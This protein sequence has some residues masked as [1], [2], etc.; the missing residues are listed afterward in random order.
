MDAKSSAAEGDPIL[1]TLSQ[2][3][4]RNHGRLLVGVSWSHHRLIAAASDRPDERYFYLSMAVRERWSVRELER[5][6]ESNLFVRYVSVK[7]DPEKCLPAEA[8]QGDL[9]PFKDHYVFDFLGLTE[10]YAEREVRKAMLAN[11]RELFL[12]LG[13]DFALVGE[14][15]PI[16]LDGD[17]FRIDL[18]LFHRRLQCLVVLE[19]KNGDFKPEYVGKCQFYLAALDEQIRLPHEKPSIGLVLCRG[20]KG[21]QLRL[22]L[23]LAARRVGVSTYQTA[24]PDQ[25]LIIR[26]MGALPRVADTSAPDS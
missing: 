21:V 17:T 2:E 25:D 19:L 22:A 7:R 23:T 1:A 15:Y 16:T 24:L 26:R 9:L 3:L 13:R 4:G 8:E 18:L 11:V 12:E 5:Q 20:A 10:P 6:I 14:E